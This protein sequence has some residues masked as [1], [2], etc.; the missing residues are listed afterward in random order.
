M[1]SLLTA[2]ERSAVDQLMDDLRQAREIGQ[3]AAN[4]E[5]ATD[6]LAKGTESFAAARMNHS[7][8]KALAGKNRRGTT[9]MPIIKILPHP[10]YCPQGAPRCRPRPEPRSARR[11]WTTRSTSSM[12]VT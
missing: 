11:C 9:L 8:Q 2:A 10:E 4:L 1:A 3:D 12:P 6:A 5:A 7:I